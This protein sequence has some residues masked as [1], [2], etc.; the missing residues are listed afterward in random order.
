MPWTTADL[1]TIT[2]SLYDLLT[3][4]LNDSVNP[5]LSIP[6]FN[7]TI[8]CGS[9]ET[10]RTGADC[11]LT[12]YLLHVGR[13]PYWRNAPPDGG[14]PQPNTIQPLSLNLYYVLTAWADANF[15]HEQQAMTIALQC[16]HNNPIY[17]PGGTNDEF[18]ISIEADTIEEMSQLWQAFHTPIRL[19]CKIKV[20]VVFVTPAKTP[21]TLFPP[22]SVV[23]LSAAPQAG[24]GPLLFGGEGLVVDPDQP[25][26]PV[27][28]AV[29]LSAP[30]AVGGSSLSILGA[31]LDQPSAGQMYLSTSDGATE[32]QV[33]GWR[34]GAAAS[35][36]DLVP[37]AAYAAPA[38]GTPPPGAYRLAVGRDTPAPA[39][40]SNTVPIV[41]A[42]RIDSVARPATPTG[43]Y[44]LNGAGFVPGSTSV[45]VGGTALTAGANPPGAG[46]FFVDPGGGS[47]AFALSTPGSFALGVSVNGV[48]SAA[49]WLT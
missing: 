13:D 31:G 44:T 1:S 6:Q 38:A 35:Q 36:L 11:Q 22:P 4:A 48:P 45:S 33:S 37:P 2:Q 3:K 30:V 8:N 29:T 5:P 18:T 19:S 17:R 9:P 12:L 26:D 25:V 16:F 49:G 14:R 40:R 47:I 32:W 24:A 20:G 27:M 39:V 7:C 34:Q 23:N 41:I 10:A 21:D 46:E 15:T 42:A 43:V 28:T